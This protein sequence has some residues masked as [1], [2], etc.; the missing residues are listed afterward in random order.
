MNDINTSF[1]NLLI[2]IKD[3]EE[4]KFMLR[5]TN[6]HYFDSDINEYDDFY[7]KIEHP[8]IPNYLK[9]LGVYPM[10][11]IYDSEEKGYDLYARDHLDEK[12]IEEFL[13]EHYTILSEEKGLERIEVNELKKL[14]EYFV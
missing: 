9:Y 1:K 4:L 3:Y 14:K 8:Y 11:M 13:D 5:A 12:S 7:E 6:E 2:L 10:V